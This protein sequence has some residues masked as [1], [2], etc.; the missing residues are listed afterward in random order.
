MKPLSF[1]GEGPTK[2]EMA[3]QSVGRKQSENSSR[4]VNE[5]LATRNAAVK[6]SETGLCL[7]GHRNWCGNAGPN[8]ANQKVNGRKQFEME[9]GQN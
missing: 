8:R 2:Q 3:H 9:P 1:Q 5:R 6:L 4:G 7:K